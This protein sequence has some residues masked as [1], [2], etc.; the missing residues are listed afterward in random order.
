LPCYCGEE[1]NG[2]KFERRQDDGQKLDRRT[3]TRS[4]DPTGIWNSESFGPKNWS[5]RIRSTTV[6]FR[7]LPI[8]DEL[9][10]RRPILIESI[11]R[12][13]GNHASIPTP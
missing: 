9:C 12:I 13:E 10:D 5:L 8:A 11:E 6:V 4:I 2:R 1:R 7:G 3:V